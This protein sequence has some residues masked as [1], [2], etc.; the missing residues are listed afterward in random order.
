MHSIGRITGTRGHSALVPIHAAVPAKLG[1]LRRAAPVG[2]AEHQGSRASRRLRG[3]PQDASC[4]PYVHAY[5]VATTSSQRHR[6]APGRL[7]VLRAG[8]GVLPHRQA[9]AQQ[10]G[11]RAEAGGCTGVSVCDNF[12]VHERSLV[13]AHTSHSSEPMPQVE[14]AGPLPPPTPHLFT[15]AVTTSSVC[16]FGGQTWAVVRPWWGRTCCRLEGRRC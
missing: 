10:A 6:G 9:R 5:A 14:A 4:G 1:V 11:A 7:R 8:L 2:L 13:G 15:A 12:H 16:L 3:P